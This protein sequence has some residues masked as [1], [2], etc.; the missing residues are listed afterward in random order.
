L[1]QAAGSGR[2][3]LR[4]QLPDMK[5]HRS[6]L[7][8][9]MAWTSVAL[10]FMVLLCAAGP[11]LQRCFVGPPG[12]LGAGAVQRLGVRPHANV[13]PD[14]SA[15]GPTAPSARRDS[16]VSLAT[17]GAVAA[18][19][20]ACAAGRGAPRR[21]GWSG[22]A[23]AITAAQHRTPIDADQREPLVAM[24]SDGGRRK[25][26]G[27]GGRVCMLTGRKKYK[28]TYR[29]YSEHKNKRYWR[30]NTMWKKLWWDRE[31]KWVR[32]FVSAAGIKL[33]DSFGLENVCKRA[34]LDLYAWCLPHWMPGSR[35][36]L[37]LKKG[38]T[39]KARR[40]RMFWPEY[41]R[42]LNKGRPLAD[43]KGEPIRPQA[44]PPWKV[45]KGRGTPPKRLK[46]TMMA[47]A[48]T[49]DALSLL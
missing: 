22:A 46:V 40:D 36:P 19:C 43:I 16:S 3:G 29:T 17:L 30:P 31:K 26:L 1:A 14:V 25:R 21:T 47:P 18:V 48:S 9:H 42:H 12:A 34:G 24:H 33:V 2:D 45:K 11:K 35:Q 23:V 20:V 38:Y 39:S 44:G 15:S 4:P 8:S 49:A 41:S 10:L 7:G 32:L 27:V 5:A 6:K 37:C 28:D 13:H